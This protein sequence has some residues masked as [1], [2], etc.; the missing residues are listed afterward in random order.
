MRQ[1]PRHRQRI[2]HAAGV[3]AA[4]PAEGGQGVLGD[5]VA[6]LHRDPLDRVGHVGDRDVDESLGQGLGAHRPSAGLRD[7]GG[8]FGKA[9]AHDIG[10]ER[11]IGARP[12]HP[13]EVRR[14]DSAQHHIGIGDGQRPAPPIACR[15][16]MRTGR[17][18][19]DPQAG[20]IEMQDRTAAG[21][22]GVDAH[23]RRAHAHPGHQRVECPLEL[24]GEVRHVGRRAAHVE[25]DHPIESGRLA[26]PRHADD[27][28]GRSRQ[29]RILA[30][31]GAGIGE[32]AIGL[33]ELQS[34]AVHGPGH[35]LD[36]AAQDR[37]QIGIDDGGVA[38]RDELDQGRDLVRHRNLGEADLAG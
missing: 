32:P 3:L 22:H 35:L 29:D 30:L 37:R 24:A 7:G 17:V 36:V 34:H 14:L 28:A 21:G 11:L 6:A 13:R 18:R 2:G 5:V 4:G 33:H 19:P 15:P 10:V 25:A 26:H 16:R 9:L 12:E 23:H 31:E 27:P 8:Q 20:A 1:H 38:A